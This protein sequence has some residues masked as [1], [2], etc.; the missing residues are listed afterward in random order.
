MELE[1]CK[2]DINLSS[3]EVKRTKN[4]IFAI[5]V[6]TLLKYFFW[7]YENIYF[8]LLALF[9][10]STLW[11]LPKKWSPT[12]P[13][14]TAIPLII[15]IAVEIVTEIITWYKNWKQDLMENNKVYQ[16]LE[17]GKLTSK[18]N[19]YIRP[20]DVLYLKKEDV[21]PVD[22]ILVDTNNNEKFSKISL[23]LLTG[24][25]NV[26][27]VIK[28]CKYYKCKDYETS[29]LL[30]SDYCINNFHNIEG[31]I[32]SQDKEYP[33]KGDNFVVGGSIIKSDDVYIWVTAC[34][35][36]KKSY[37][38][39]SNKTDRKKNRIDAFV[40]KYMMN[41]N[42]VLLG[43]LIFITSFVKIAYSHEFN[44][45]NIVFNIVQNWILFNGL[46]PFSVKILL[47][48]SRNLQTSL[49]NK[50][51]SNVTINNPL[52]I[53]DIGKS[54]KILTDKT[55]TLTKNELEFSKLIEVWKN[56]I[57][58]V[59]TFEYKHHD[60]SLDFHK[61]LGLCI[62]QT[63][64]N[65]STPED[66]TIR[67]RYQQ[68]NDRVSQS[69]DKISLFINNNMKYDYKYVEIGGL[70]FT[71]ERR[72]SSKIVKDDNG[73]LYIYCKGAMDIVTKK[74]KAKY[75]DEIKRLDKLISQTHP[76]LR[77]LAC[78]F[79]EISQDEL[80]KTMMD[81]MNRSA[82]VKALEEN[83]DF[84][85][86]IGIRDNLQPDVQS[87]INR[88]KQSNLHCCLLTGDRKITA[89]AIGKESGILDNEHDIFDFNFDNREED[90]SDINNKTLLFS[91]TLLESITKDTKHSE[92]FYDK[93]TRCKNFI[94]YNLIPEHKRKLANVLE[95]KNVKTLTIGDGFNDIGM[96]DVS[97]IS[98]AIKG[99]SFVENSADFII[100]EF[101]DLSQLFD[102]NIDSYYKNSKLINFTFLRCSSIIFSIVTHCLLNYT[103]F[104]PSLF[105]GFVL[106]A[107]NFAWTIPSTGF[108]TLKSNVI[109]DRDTYKKYDYFR[110]KL[111]SLT[112]YEYTTLWNL[113]GIVIGII[114]TLINN[115]W[116]PDHT[117][118]DDLC[119][120][121]LISFLNFKYA[122]NNKP[123]LYGIPISS[124]GVVVF[125][126][127][128]V[129]NGSL[130]SV[131]DSLINVSKYYWLSLAATY[132]GVSFLL[133]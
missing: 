85:G 132:L 101:R 74:T 130:F 5:P 126:L 49:N 9:Q 25:S 86:I 100:K 93:L 131:I 99:N 115:Y 7:N 39:K 14:S 15:C 75:L 122:A 3:N 116:F 42:A 66:K 47:I 31:K 30:I 125:A 40:G 17:N 33:I 83:L 12:G 57:I 109:P 4:T 58:D 54:V 91:G 50:T 22:G 76:E 118:F 70:D 106:Q 18:K 27:Y 129:F 62:H 36:N 108:Y 38:K 104:V 19:K 92:L 60:V 124:L 13:F 119:G 87:T 61:C 29:R 37:L 127:Y 72:L 112:S 98:V 110:N 80:N 21:C 117:H 88:L 2:P 121:V 82:M 96:F 41:V 56:N 35:K 133:V 63:E 105:N 128:M 71:F 65:Y 89:I 8:L 94:G 123:D 1:F 90:I 79:R 114:L 16:C 68:L 69:G 111:L 59:E 103:S 113:A 46:I 45:Y 43:V 55:G 51:N 78:A 81:S 20:G 102:I 84:L 77:L 23:A 26:N 48:L 6:L 10:L 52:Q 28:P 44:L 64:G 32:I 107:F 11:F 34:G 53:D 73:K 67:Y 24:E 95:N 120:L 97:S